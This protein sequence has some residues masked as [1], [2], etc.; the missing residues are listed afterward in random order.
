[1][2]MVKDDTVLYEIVATQII[3]V[4]TSILFEIFRH[5]VVEHFQK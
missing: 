3:T 1:M 5:S 4:M 2:E